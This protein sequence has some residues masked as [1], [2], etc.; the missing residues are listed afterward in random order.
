MAPQ[1]M[2]GVTTGFPFT[3]RALTA[4][5][6][7]A[8]AEEAIKVTIRNTTTDVETDLV[9]TTDY[10][11]SINSNGVGGTVTVVDA[12]SSDY[13][14]TIYREYLEK[15]GSDYNDRNSFPSETLENNIDKLTMIDQQQTEQ[16]DR[17]PKYSTTSGITNPSIEDPIAGRALVFDSNGNIV[18][19]DGYVTSE[20]LPASLTGKKRQQLQ[21]KVDES[22]YELKTKIPTEARDYDS[23]QD[24]VDATNIKEI[25]LGQGTTTLTS[26][27]DL[28]GKYQIIEGVGKTGTTLK[29]STG[30]TKIF[31]IEESS[32]PATPSD[33]VIKDMTLDGDDVSGLYGLKIKHRVRGVLERLN[34]IDCPNGVWL[35]DTYP[36]MIRTLRIAGSTGTGLTLNG[37]NHASII[38]GTKIT[39]CDTCHLKIDDAGTA[40]DKNLAVTFLN[41]DIEFG[42]GIG[43]DH[44]GGRYVQFIN[45]YI[46]E[47]IESEVF[48]LTSGTAICNGGFISYG[49]TTSS[50]L[51][52]LS[53]GGHLRIK[54]ATIGGDTY[55]TVANLTTGTNGTIMLEDCE[56]Y[57]TLGGVP[58]LDGWEVIANGLER[59]NF[60]EKLGRNWSS[61]VYNTCTATETKSA[62]KIRVECD[63]AGG[64]PITDGFTVYSALENKWIKGS[65]LYL[66]LE[67]KTNIAVKVKLTN[68]IHNQGTGA[69]LITNLASTGGAEKTVL[70]LAG[71]WNASSDYTHIEIYPDDSVTVADGDYIELNEA[72]LSDERMRG[73]G[74]PLENLY[75]N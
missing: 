33:F 3:L 46:G 74:T 55:G 19:S 17:T 57:I 38:E 63:T 59:A 31:D 34:V 53:G 16:I 67:L 27:I 41:A 6:T 69:T 29:A 37:S 42:A 39:S 7:Q 13:T 45:G 48:K 23:I 1:A 10:T 68:G 35:Q 50:Y 18:N 54:N 14:I 5:P 21:V 49:N 11:V 9:Y 65:N 47:A 40:L 44:D 8:D 52:N 26:A 12:Q 70:L 62:K 73:S 43:V 24:A 4:D 64:T 58:V 60:A 28:K 32:L 20:T 56:A 66:L 25:K 72:R 71:T 30:M 2:D 61:A 22:G 75:K 51:A 36:I 15:Q